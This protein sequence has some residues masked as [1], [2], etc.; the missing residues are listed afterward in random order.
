MKPNAYAFKAAAAQAG[1]VNN[2]L[3]DRED[4]QPGIL[5]FGMGNFHRCHQAVYVDKLL[6][7][8]STDWG[9]VGVS[10]RSAKLRNQLAPQDFLY[11]QVT[12]SEA[13]EF[14]IVGSILDI[15]VAPENPAAVIDRVAHGSIKLVTSTITEKGYCLSSG[16]I[17][18]EHPD[19]IADGE[20]LE[21]PKT[22]YGYLAAGLIQRRKNGG[23]PLS[24][25]CCDNIQSGGAHLQTGVRM[26]LLQHD[27]DSADWATQQVSFASSMVDRVSPAT[28]EPLKQLVRTALNLEDAWPVAAEPFSQWVIE[29]N[30][31]AA[32]PPFDK[33]GALFTDDIS[34]Y[35]QA[36]LRFLNAGHSIISV[37]G[38]LA[39]HPSVHQA[40]EQPSIQ[41]F[42]VRAL[43]ENVL[44]VATM[45]PGFKGDEYIGDVIKRFKNS[46]LPYTVAQV[47]TDSSQKIQQRWFPTV[48]D[49]LARNADTAMISFVIAAWVL[50]VQKALL[51]GELN[52]PLGE[53]FLAAQNQGGDIIHRFLETA[54]AKQ[55]EF[56]SSSPFMA[57]V[58]SHYTTLKN[59]DTSAALTQ[60]I[61][62]REEVPHA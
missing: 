3:Y 41:D 47:N 18:T 51:A 10:M 26:L 43:H 62:Q 53:E 20:S 52:D 54:G 46:A 57:S 37:L 4:I 15:L 56:F 22:I 30:F 34:L 13:T 2:G 6:S 14:R 28:D 60:F 35:E 59:T 5:H 19:I 39:G 17:D 29:D 16:Q 8:G 44:P 48:D 12:L 42:V 1:T 11:T 38:Y 31:A 21:S 36:K 55:F 25:L 58:L 45:P 27:K 23:A 40:L 7:Q 32:R 33:V 49:A 24:V 61:A 9:I 50:F